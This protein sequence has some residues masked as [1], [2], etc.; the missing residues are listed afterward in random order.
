MSSNKYPEDP[1]TA[2][3]YKLWRKDVL[4]WKKL[5]SI[6]ANKQGLALQYVCKGNEEVHEA[7][8]NIPD[9]QVEC[10]EGF[11]NV[12]A[13]IDK[14]FNVDKRD[15]EKKECSDFDSLIK[16]ERQTM[17]N[18][19][20]LFDSL[21]NK[22]KAH[23]NSM[24]DNM[25][26][27]KLIKAANL[28]KSQKQMIDLVYPKGKY[29]DVKT[30]LKNMFGETMSASATVKTEPS[31][32]TY[33]ARKKCECQESQQSDT[34]SEDSSE[35]EIMYGERRKKWYK[36][37]KGKM[38]SSN[39]SQYQAKRGKNPLDQFG[40]ITRCN[41]CE[42]INHWA[43]KCPDKDEAK[44]QSYFEIQLFQGA[45]EDS[46]QVLNLIYETSGDSSLRSIKN[47]VW[48]KVL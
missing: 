25:L 41:I 20:N 34:S 6:E 19:V 2:S 48:C 36:P 3:N 32:S 27:T 45:M 24:S 13:V 37:K 22:T 43:D 40:N 44:R 4:I 12:L 7:V 14:L 5:S 23:G 42:S 35:N 38:Q 17:A 30:A 33:I 31:S 29:E 9:E 21:Y 46:Y 10:A 8:T 11:N 39:K 47:C 16:D 15:Q 1:S 26:V 28:T 18:F